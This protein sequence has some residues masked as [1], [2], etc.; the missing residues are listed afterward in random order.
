MKMLTYEEIADAMEAV[1]GAVY[2]DGGEASLADVMTKMGL[3]V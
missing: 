1:I 2:V 3:D